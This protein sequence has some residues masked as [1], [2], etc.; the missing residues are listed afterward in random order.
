[1]RCVEDAHPLGSYGRKDENRA[2]VVA[3]RIAGKAIAASTHASESHLTYT[4]I[5][6]TYRQWLSIEVTIKKKIGSM[7]AIANT[8]MALKTK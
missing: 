1:M 5:A 8:Y 6:G 7:E 2:S 4:S 3:P